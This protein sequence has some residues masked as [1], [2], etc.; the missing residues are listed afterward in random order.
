MSLSARCLHHLRLGG[1]LLAVVAIRFEICAN[2]NLVSV[3][4]VV[5]VFAISLG[6]GFEALPGYG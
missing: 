3:F 6:T 1:G 4:T 2:G 5:S